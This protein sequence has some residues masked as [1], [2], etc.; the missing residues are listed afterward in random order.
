MIVHNVDT[1][2]VLHVADTE[3]TVF[4]SQEKSLQVAYNK[5]SV[6]LRLGKQLV[7]FGTELSRLKQKSENSRNSFFLL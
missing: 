2:F 1:I 7:S 5:K 3:I 6:I 4:C